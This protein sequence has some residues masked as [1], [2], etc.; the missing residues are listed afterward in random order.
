MC[1]RLNGVFLSHFVAAGSNLSDQVGSL[2]V[3]LHGAPSHT[4]TSIPDFGVTGLH[5]WRKQFLIFASDVWKCCRVAYF[6]ST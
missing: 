2:C 5:L 4:P 1:N 3:R 6:V